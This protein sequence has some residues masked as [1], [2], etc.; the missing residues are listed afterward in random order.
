MRYRCPCGYESQEAPSAPDREI[1]CVYH[2]HRRS[3]I[4]DLADIV[5]ME[6]VQ[7]PAASP[8]REPEVAGAAAG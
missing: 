7:P 3:D 1:V 2:I 4:R 5:C 6:P 8:A